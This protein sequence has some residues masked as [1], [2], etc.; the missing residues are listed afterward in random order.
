MQSA[1]LYQLSI[2]GE[3]SSKISAEIRN[4]Y[5]QVEWKEIIGFRNFAIH[6]YFAVNQPIVWTTATEDTIVLK[7]QISQIL[8]NEY[9][10]FE[11]EGK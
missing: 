7:A 6:T 10:D 1:V 2:I 5:P 9:L 4:R 8:Q 3:A 11:F